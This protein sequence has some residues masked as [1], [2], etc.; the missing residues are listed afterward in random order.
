LHE[1]SS[2]AGRQ[3]LA[4]TNMDWST[5]H[6]SGNERFAF[7]RETVCR[8]ILNVS[9]EHRPEHFEA[10]IRSRQFGPLRFASFAAARHDVVRLKSDIARNAD[11]HCLISL[12]RKGR[13]L[14]TQNDDTFALDPGEISIIN[15]DRPFRVQ[16]RH[17]VSRVL[18]VIPRKTLEARAPWLRRTAT[19]KVALASPF[20]DLAAR[21]LE[22]LAG[23]GA[24][25]ESEASLLTDNLCNLLA[26]ATT[27]DARDRVIPGGVPLD[28]LLAYC[29]QNLSEPDLSPAL[30]AA[31][32]GISVRTL[33]LRF[34]AAGQTFGQW[35][36]QNRLDLCRSILAGG[37]PL[38]STIADIA[39]GCGFRD[40]SHFNKSFRA[41]FGMTPG[42]AQRSPDGFARPSREV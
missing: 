6:V 9:M 36:L 2:E 28:A 13:A 4:V 22:Q 19:R 20:A 32:F 41:R 16:F 21:H 34:K 27:R 31:Y 37:R 7:W 30:V 23:D 24:M 26:L 18:A 5:D 33:H 11:D 40:L 29:R 17:S 3:A 39:F 25:S 42:D 8:T 15:G 38:R 1:T 12:Q 10:H 14:I 35:V